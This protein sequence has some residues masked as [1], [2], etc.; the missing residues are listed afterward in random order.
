M[1]KKEDKMIWIKVDGMLHKQFKQ[2]LKARSKRDGVHYLE[3][4]EIGKGANNFMRHAIE[5]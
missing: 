2:V 1:T 4:T 3:Q 5:D